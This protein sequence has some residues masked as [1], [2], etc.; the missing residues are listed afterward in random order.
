MNSDEFMHGYIDGFDVC[1][2]TDD[3]SD[4]EDENENKTPV[5][6][7]IIYATNKRIIIRYPY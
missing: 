1:S 2:G 6:P 5:T 3:N 4:M 7:N